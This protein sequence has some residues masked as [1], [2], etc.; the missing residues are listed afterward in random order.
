MVGEGQRQLSRVAFH[1]SSFSVGRG[2]L[3]YSVS[4]RSSLGFG[5]FS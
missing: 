1:F 3:V 2:K 4:K 5:T